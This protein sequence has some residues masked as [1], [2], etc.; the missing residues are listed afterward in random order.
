M[1]LDGI[2]S[3]PLFSR[4]VPFRLEVK[5]YLD[6]FARRVQEIAVAEGLAKEGGNFRLWQSLAAN[7]AGNFRRML[8][9]VESG[10]FLPEVVC[11]AVC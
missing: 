1:M 4:C 11:G 9:V 5:P 8:S 6:D 3:D 7:C 10:E 2:D